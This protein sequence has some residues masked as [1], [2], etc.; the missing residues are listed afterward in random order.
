MLANHPT[1][2][3]IFESVKGA[4][5]LHGT[6]SYNTAE[7]DMVMNYVRKIL[8]RS[9]NNRTVCCSD[10]GIISPYR[11]QCNRIRAACENGFEEIMVGSAEIF[12]GKEKPII[13]VSTVRTTDVSIG[14]VKDPRVT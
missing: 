14:F 4:C 9:W 5:K 12:Q 8:G 10:I 11:S 2:P 1:F 3:I 13:L 7:V 6:S